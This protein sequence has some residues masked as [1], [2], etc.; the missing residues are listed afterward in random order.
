MNLRRLFY[1]MSLGLW[2]FAVCQRTHKRWAQPESLF[3]T[4]QALDAKVFDAGAN[5]SLCNKRGGAEADPDGDETKQKRPR[6]KAA[7]TREFA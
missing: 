6:P 2:F 4:I 7:S 1:S 5:V 3:K